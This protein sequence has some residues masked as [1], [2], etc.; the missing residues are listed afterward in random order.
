MTAILILAHGAT[1]GRIWTGTF[2]G[3][4]LALVALL[5]AL[6]SRQRGRRLL[7][8]LAWGFGW[9]ALLWNLGWCG[10][11]LHWEGMPDWEF[12]DA[13]RHT[14]HTELNEYIALFGPSTLLSTCAVLISRRARKQPK[15]LE[16]H[17]PKCAKCG[18]LLVGLTLARCP[19]CGTPFDPVFLEVN[20]NSA[21][22]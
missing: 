17:P 21:A 1:V 3:L 20:K 16:S 5:I 14:M 9:F 7:A 6:A 13:G 15:C 12:W 2:V 19:E 18:Y 11:I 22:R 8:S 4:P 10:F